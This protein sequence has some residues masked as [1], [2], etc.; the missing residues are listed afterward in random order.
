[1]SIIR[2]SYSDVAILRDGASRLLG[3]RTFRV[4]S[5]SS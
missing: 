1:L 2:P 4:A 5:A 3:M